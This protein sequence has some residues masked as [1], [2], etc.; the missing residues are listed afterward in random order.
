M[1]VGIGAGRISVTPSVARYGGLRVGIA[2][3]R[4]IPTKGM[5]LDIVRRE[6]H[7]GVR[8]V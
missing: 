2:F 4:I 8:G 6:E 7:D 1:C 5:N 3:A